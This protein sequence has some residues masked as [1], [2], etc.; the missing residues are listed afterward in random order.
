MGTSI[1][2]QAERT[3]DQENNDIYGGH[4]YRG[5]MEYDGTE[6]LWWISRGSAEKVTAYRTD[7]HAHNAIDIIKS[8]WAYEQW[9]NQIFGEGWEERIDLKDEL[10]ED[11]F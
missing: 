10:E 2:L 7:E 9:T 1:E 8:T 5:R 3:Y 4:R 6:D 11:S